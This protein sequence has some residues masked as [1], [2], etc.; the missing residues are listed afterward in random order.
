MF[1]IFIHAVYKSDFFFWSQRSLPAEPGFLW[2]WEP[3]NLHIAADLPQVC[4]LVWQI[5]TRAMFGCVWNGA[6]F[7]SLPSSALRWRLTF[8]D[9]SQ[10]ILSMPCEVAQRCWEQREGRRGSMGVL[11][12]GTVLQHISKHSSKPWWAVVNFWMFISVML[13]ARTRVQTTSLLCNLPLLPAWFSRDASASC[14]AVNVMVWALEYGL[15]WFS[16]EEQFD[17]KENF[18]Q[19]HDVKFIYSSRK[20]QTDACLLFL[21][22]IW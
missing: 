2:V 1:R 18:I 17:C 19:K 7:V 8:A 16:R 13:N 10:L 22:E 9:V 11:S 15:S 21:R 12:A 5:S 3:A 20:Q 4:E 14:S 6:E